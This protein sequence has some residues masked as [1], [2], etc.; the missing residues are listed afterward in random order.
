[1]AIIN[2]QEP[3]I[4]T[5]NYRFVCAV[6]TAKVDIEQT[7]ADIVKLSTAELATETDIKPFGCITILPDRQYR[8]LAATVDM[9]LA[10]NTSN[11]DD[12]GDSNGPQSS[13]DNICSLLQ[14]LNAVAETATRH[15][16]DA[17]VSNIIHSVWQ[18]FINPH[19]ERASAVTVSQPLMNR[20][21]VSRINR[22]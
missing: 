2:F 4:F 16:L 22:T 14:K 18:K 20:Y 7:M 19:G 21:V 9:W 13:F 10:A 15:N 8:R 3:L 5:G 17:A 1:V 12:N 6:C 11:G